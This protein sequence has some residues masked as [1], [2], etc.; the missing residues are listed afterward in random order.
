MLFQDTTVSADMM[1]RCEQKEDGAQKKNSQGMKKSERKGSLKGISFLFPPK[2][3]MKAPGKASLCTFFSGWKRASLTVETAL[4]LPLFFMGVVAMISFMDIY[5]IQTEHLT[6]LCQKAKTAGMYA[7]MPDGGGL[8][9]ITIPDLYSYTPVGGIIP[10]PKVRIYNQVKVHAWT[11]EVRGCFRS[12]EN[13]KAEAMVYVAESGEVYHKDPGC[14]Y[15]NVTVKQAAG[16]SVASLRNDYGEKY[17]PCETC[18]RNQKAAWTVYIT[19]KGNRFHN[20]GS[21]S[22]LKRSV[23]LVRESEAE[24][25][26]PCSRCG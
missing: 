13:E 15:L 2:H 3:R 17:Y 18:S 11:G 25:L 16:K 7:Y 24:K 23:R 22:G 10:L 4:V 6:K 1:D 12:S 26:S 9:E 14:R 19:G 21:C 5:R 8:E 20:H